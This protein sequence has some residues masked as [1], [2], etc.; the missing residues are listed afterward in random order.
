MSEKADHKCTNNDL[1]T[2]E[3]LQDLATE[4]NITLVTNSQVLAGAERVK[5]QISQMAILELFKDNKEFD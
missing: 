1:L 3:I 2:A 5:A 4:I